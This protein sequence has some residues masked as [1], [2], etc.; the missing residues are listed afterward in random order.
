MGLLCNS[1][2]HRGMR[3]DIRECSWRWGGRWVVVHC[4][5]REKLEDA[6][7]IDGPGKGLAQLRGISRL[8]CHV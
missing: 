5:L 8:S 3:V 7:P 4:H 1:V 2:M 6:V